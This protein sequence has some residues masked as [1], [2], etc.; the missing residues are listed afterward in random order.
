MNDYH[1]DPAEGVTKGMHEGAGNSSECIVCG[2]CEL[3]FSLFVCKRHHQPW[4]L[5]E[6]TQLNH[7]SL[8][9]LER[10]TQLQLMAMSECGVISVIVTPYN[11]FINE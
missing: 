10:G 9:D 2:V 6:Q 5:Y 8:G 11:P 4:V 1:Q 7:K 3:T